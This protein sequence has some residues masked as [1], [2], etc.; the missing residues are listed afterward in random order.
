MTAVIAGI[1]IFAA[2]IAEAAISS[3]NDAR[4]RALG[5][6]EPQDDVIGVMTLVYPTSFVVMLAEGWWRGAGADVLFAIG[7]AVFVVAKA[8]KYWAIRT[9]G[10]RWTFRVLVPPGAVSTRGGPYR[11]L[12]HPNYVGVIGELLG[13][14][15]AMQ[16]L[17]S[18]PIAV[19]AFVVILMRR[20][21]VEERALAGR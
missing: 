12:A 17:F 19:A 13:V 6:A 5:A 8:L 20:I 3:R 21:R 4:L 10:P 1:L 2:M 15:I 18:G 14:A 7:A 11:W 16:A 9:L